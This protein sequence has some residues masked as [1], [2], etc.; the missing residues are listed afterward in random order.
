MYIAINVSHPVL[1]SA[2]LPK[3]GGGGL[4]PLCPSL[5]PSLCKQQQQSNEWQNAKVKYFKVET[6]KKIEEAR[7]KKG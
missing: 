5:P 1:K 7:N 3:S 6:A 2:G 4:R